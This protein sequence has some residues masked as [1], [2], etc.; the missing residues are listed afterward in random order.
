MATSQRSRENIQETISMVRIRAMVKKRQW[1][2]RVVA[3]W[4]KRR[5]DCR[6]LSEGA[7]IAANEGAWN[8]RDCPGRRL[9]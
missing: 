8:K 1:R 5:G 7:A 3:E 2:R 4:L 6:G 9:L